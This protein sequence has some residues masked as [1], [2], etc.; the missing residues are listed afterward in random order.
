MRYLLP[1]PMFDYKRKDFERFMKILLNKYHSTKENPQLFSH[2][3]AAYVCMTRFHES[4]R[5]EKKGQ[6]LINIHLVEI[7]LL[8]NCVFR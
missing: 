6:I 1:K 8:K 2:I 7:R 5:P 4:E 3:I